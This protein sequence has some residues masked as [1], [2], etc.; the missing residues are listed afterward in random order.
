MA[1][2]PI[3]QLIW[4]VEVFVTLSFEAWQGDSS[5]LLDSL[6]LAIREGVATQ[7]AT[8]VLLRN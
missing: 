8:R 7:P 2:E 5:S 1:H 4:D 6:L 3:E